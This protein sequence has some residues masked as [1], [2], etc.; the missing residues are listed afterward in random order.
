MNKQ[1]ML[2]K[3]KKLGI[4]IPQIV[5]E[6][7]E[8][9]LLNSIFQSSFGKD[10]VFRGGTVL[11]LA[12][13][14]PRYSDDLDFSQIKE[15]N[16]KIFKDWCVKIAKK[17]TSLKL[18]EVLQK[19]YTLFANFQINDSSLE[20]S[21]NIKVEISCRKT[22]W[23]KNQN[24]ILSQLFSQVT[25]ITVLAQVATLPQIKKEKQSISPLRIRDIFDLWFIGQKLKEQ[26]SMDFSGFSIREIKQ[27]LHKLLP[28]EQWVLIEKWISKK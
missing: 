28:Q 5:R 27:D 3:Q 7:Y 6:E 1:L 17:N 4:S 12:Y 11:R 14:S 8:M 13:G 19:Y 24:Y 22:K 20:R 9:I 2:E 25:P 16:E 21:I 15:I 23:V 18:I 26:V 10:L